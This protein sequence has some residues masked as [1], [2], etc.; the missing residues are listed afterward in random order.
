MEL[1][2][3]EYGNIKERRYTTIV[4]TSHNSCEI[5]VYADFDTSSLIPNIT[6]KRADSFVLGPFKMLPIQNGFK[7]VLQIDDLAVNGS[8]QITIRY[9][10]YVFDEE[11]QE[12]VSIY[13]KTCALA[14]AMVYEAIPKPHDALNAILREIQNG[15]LLNG[16]SAYELA[17]DSG[18]K[19]TLEDWLDS[20]KGDDGLNASIYSGTEEPEATNGIWLDD[21]PIDDSVAPEKLVENS[22]PGEI[23]ESSV[24]GEITQ[25]RFI[26]PSEI[27]IDETL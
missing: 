9:E 6:L 14:T 24:P 7:Y 16:K 8:L 2:F 20:L 21:T 27:I 15:N 10:E 17:V 23:Q 3:D 12:Q 19:G 13:T 25:D 4:A 18:F 22:V 26:I 1:Y 11:T 5:K